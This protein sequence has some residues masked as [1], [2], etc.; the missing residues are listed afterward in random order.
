[1][2]ARDQANLEFLL[3]LSEDG[4]RNWYD[5]ASE[6]DIAYASELLDSY[7]LS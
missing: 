3:N 6:D 1:M 7:W 5:Q 2:N 4:L